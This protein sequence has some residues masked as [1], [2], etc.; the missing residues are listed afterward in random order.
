MNRPQDRIGAMGTPSAKD[1]IIDVVRDLP[2]TATFDE[3]LRELA[4]ARMV[5]RDLADADAGR[6]IGHGEMRRQIDSWRQ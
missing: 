6:T 5:E 1:R 3:I 2:D 4:V